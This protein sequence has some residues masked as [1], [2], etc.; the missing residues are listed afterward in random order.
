[1]SFED[2]HNKASAEGYTPKSHDKNFGGGA[3][4][5]LV[6]ELGAIKEGDDPKDY[7]IPFDGPRNIV[8]IVGSILLIAT[9]GA[10]M[11]ILKNKTIGAPAH[12]KESP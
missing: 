1:M 11:T 7:F 10:G 8:V 6:T 5:F 12:E 3:P 4:P 9:I 2:A